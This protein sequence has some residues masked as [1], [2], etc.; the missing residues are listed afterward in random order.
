M[1][2]SASG[3]GL[4][5]E[6]DYTSDLGLTDR[7]ILIYAEGSIPDDTL[8]HFREKGINAPV[9]SYD[10]WGLGQFAQELRHTARVMVDGNG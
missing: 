10:R 8:R 7:L 5:Y 9:L 2:V 6:A 4:A 1:D 3:S